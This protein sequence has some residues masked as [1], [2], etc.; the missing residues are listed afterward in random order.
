MPNN[1]KTFVRRETPWN[2]AIAQRV[3]FGAAWLLGFGLYAAI[4]SALVIAVPGG[5]LRRRGPGRWTE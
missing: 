3:A 4:G 1:A 2:T 5:I